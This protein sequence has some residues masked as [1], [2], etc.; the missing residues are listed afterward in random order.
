MA[1]TTSSQVFTIVKKTKNPSSIFTLHGFKINTC[2]HIN[3]FSKKLHC[4]HVNVNERL[5]E[6]INIIIVYFFLT[7]KYK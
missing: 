4:C 1:H 2:C 5:T 3:V 7:H 6:Q